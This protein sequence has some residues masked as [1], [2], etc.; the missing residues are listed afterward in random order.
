MLAEDCT[1]LVLSV[2][3]L[4]VAIMTGVCAGGLSVSLSRSANCTDVYSV[5][6]VCVEKTWHCNRDAPSV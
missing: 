6:R 2:E 1:L 5:G 4:R 3:S